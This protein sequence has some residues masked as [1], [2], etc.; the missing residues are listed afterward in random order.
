MTNKFFWV[1]LSR[2]DT[3]VSNLLVVGTQVMV[4]KMILKK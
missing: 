2:N 3:T 1:F 4:M